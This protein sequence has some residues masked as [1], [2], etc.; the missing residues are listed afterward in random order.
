MTARPR[1]LIV[2]RE[3][4]AAARGNVIVSVTTVILVAGLCAAVLL[5][6]GRAVGA[7]QAV[8]GS[9]DSVGSRAVVVTASA[10]AGLTSD[11]LDRLAHV[12]GIQWAGAFGEAIDT[13][14]TLIPDGNK[15]P[16][17]L[18]YGSQ[19]SALGVPASVALP[20][21]TAWATR[22]GLA[23]LG[24]PGG[25]GSVTTQRGDNYTVAGS[26]E[27]P[28]WLGMLEPSL[29][30][31]TPAGSRGDIAILVVIAERPDLVTPVAAVIQ[32]VLGVTDPST[33]TIETSETIAELRMLVQGQLG[34]FGRG[35]VA[36]ILAISG[37]LVAMVMTGLVIIRRKDFGRRRALGATRGL[38]MAIVL[39]QTVGLASAGA[40]VGAASASIALAI[41]G[42]PL[43]GVSFTAGVCILAVVVSGFAALAP[44]VVASRR[45]PIRE[46]RVP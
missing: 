8:L 36:L 41:S 1:W 6:T 11:V 12:D 18:A 44:A 25:V 13:R 40:V 4:L 42:D 19:L 2:A 22:D 24:L 15:V 30:V 10:S 29:I 43:P 39:V 21:T 32:S 5:T 31:P 27:L 9:I 46:L 37:L 7:E 14:N 3:A 34:E 16:A 35:L 28:D 38:I 45:D 23:R 20:G 17:R 26:L 33:V